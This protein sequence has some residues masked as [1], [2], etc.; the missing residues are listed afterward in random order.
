MSAPE[1]FAD[2]GLALLT[3]WA[4]VTDQLI[5]FAAAY[6]ARGGANQF[7]NAKAVAAEGEELTPEQIS[8]NVKL[9]ESS[10]AALDVVTHHNELIAWYD[11]GRRVRVAIRRTD[12]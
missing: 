8:S 5:T 12:Y 11:A 6:E 2:T 3:Q 7:N 4:Q 1:A 10:A 9:D